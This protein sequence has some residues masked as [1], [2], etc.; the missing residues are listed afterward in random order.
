MPHLLLVVCFDHKHT[1]WIQPYASGNSVSSHE[2]LDKFRVFPNIQGLIS[3]TS[4]KVL[5]KYI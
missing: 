4:P 2:S 3:L 5:A 1:Q